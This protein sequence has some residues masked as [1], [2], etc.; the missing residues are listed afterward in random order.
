[1][2]GNTCPQCPLQVWALGSL[3]LAHEALL[4]G[5]MEHVLAALKLQARGTQ[6]GLH[7]A[8]A[9]RLAWGAAALAARGLLPAG[10]G[11]PQLQQFWD[12]LM[13]CLDSAV[14]WGLARAETLLRPE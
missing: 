6:P 8:S 5:F 13:D 1:M 4:G 2:P 14:R 9:A 7:A 11:P 12:A 10:V 3:G